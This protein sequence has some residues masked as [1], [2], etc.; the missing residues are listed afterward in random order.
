MPVVQ[1]ANDR[2]VTGPETML[3]AIKDLGM[4]PLFPHVIPG[5]SIREMTPKG[6]WF[7]DE[8]GILGPWDW[9]IEVVRS[10]EVA[11]G[12]FLPGGR[13]AFATIGCYR[14]LMN[15]R[16]SLPKCRPEGLAR[17]ILESISEAGSASPSMLRKQFG[18]RKAELDTILT[19]L[20]YATRVVVGDIARVYRGPD[21]HYSGWQQSTVC[22]PEALFGSEDEDLAAFFGLPKPSAQPQHRHT[23]EES[24]MRLQDRIRSRFPAVTDSQIRKILD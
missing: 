19:R 6:F 16:R 7:D 3:Q 14:E 22:T 9:K 11:Y 4:V 2:P 13:T 15:W 21:L 5:C 17:D 1:K 23:P 8:D 20:E 24:R 18:L 12:K 10:G